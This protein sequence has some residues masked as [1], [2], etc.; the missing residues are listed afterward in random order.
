MG[1][2]VHRV[3]YYETDKM[4]ITHH[5]NYVRWMEEARVDFLDQIGW[6]FDRLEA[7]GIVSP[8][9]GLSCR[10]IAPTTF[11]DRVEIAVSVLEYRGPRLTVKY[12]MWKEGK[13]VFTGTSSHCFLSKEGKFLR[14]KR[15][16]PEFDAKL[17]A[18]AGE[19]SQ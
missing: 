1:G 7:M 6:G 14:L 11:R 15:D 3:Q 13:A 18:L 2:Y 16:F 8:V 19:S 17:R 9:V 12:E 4:G 10:Y 5:A